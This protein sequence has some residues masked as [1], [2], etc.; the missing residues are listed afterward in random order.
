MSYTYN[1][2]IPTIKRDLDC[3]TTGV[4]VGAAP[5]Q[6]IS[7]VV[8]NTTAT[9]AYFKI[10]D[11]ATA[12]AS[13]DTPIKTILLPANSNTIIVQP[14]QTV[15]AEPGTFQFTLGFGYRSVTGVADN[16]TTSPAANGTVL[17]AEY[18]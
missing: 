13:T 15:D 1:A 14:R 7:L 16:D 6:I 12:P 4:L 10:Y 8:A 17:N 5:I 3:K 9:A 2:R 11:K 18:Y